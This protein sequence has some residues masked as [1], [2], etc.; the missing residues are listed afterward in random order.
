MEA[1]AMIDMINQHIIPSCKEAGVGPLRKLNGCVNTLKAK[2][3]EIHDE[4]DEVARATK[5]RNLRLE[6]MIE[7][8]KTCD[9]T[10]AIVPAN[11]WTL[12][13]YKELLFLDQGVDM[14][15]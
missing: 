15:Y 3:H 13:T 12:G 1:L 4:A 7:I 11:L 10:E 14:N 9:E 2:L 5:A 6:T 8:R